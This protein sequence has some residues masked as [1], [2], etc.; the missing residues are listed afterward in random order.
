M[1]NRPPAIDLTR[2]TLGIFFLCLMVAACF[3]ILRPFL[4]SLAWAVMIVVATWPLLLGVQARL[5][6]NRYL[7]VLVMTGTMLLVFVIPFALAIGTIV[8]HA[9]QIGAWAKSLS[10][11]S[12][13][14][15]PASLGG[16]PLVGPKLAGGWQHLAAMPPEEWSGRF[17]PYLKST[18]GWLAAKAGSFGMMF[19]HILLTLGL[20]AL[21]YARG[22]QAGQ[23]LVRFAHKV[24]GSQGET[25][26]RLASLAIRAVALGVV[27]TSLV[28]S[29][30]AG[31]GLALA[32]I[33]LAT[34]LTALVFVLTV[35]QIGPLP[36]LVP[37][38]IWL[39]WQDDILWGTVLLVWSLVVVN[40]DAFL[41]PMLIKRGSNLPLILIFGGVLGGLFAFGIIGLFIGPVVLA[42][43]YTL[44]MAWIGDHST[45]QVASARADVAGDNPAGEN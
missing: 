5:R 43:S 27:V 16:L 15:P 40:L 28:Q 10:Q 41:R 30:L 22:E 29:I 18:G 35:A 8:D 19:V 25:S 23:T 21:L 17:A 42:V 14:A 34:L 33:P 1:T 39:Y 4:L 20:S 2:A 9:P 36:V 44:L 31:L 38:V 3:W 12:L 32:G 26:V 24:A 11:L 6:G 7:A 45:A 13:P 37:A